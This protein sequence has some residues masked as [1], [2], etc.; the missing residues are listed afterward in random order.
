MS[1]HDPLVRLKHMRDAALEAMEMA[2]GRE[3]ADLDRDKILERALRYQVIVVGQAASSLSVE[4][5]A[6]ASDVPWKG[7]I[8]MRHV[9]VH[10][11]DLVDLDQVWEAVTVDIPALLVKLEALIAEIEAEREQA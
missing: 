10:G 1:R 6:R 9:V 4:T 2:E 3:R 5:R 11:Y 8:G 7:I